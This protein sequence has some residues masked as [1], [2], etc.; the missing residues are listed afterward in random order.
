MS[1][2]EPS[3]AGGSRRRCTRA[4]YVDGQERERFF[5][6]ISASSFKDLDHC[7]YLVLGSAHAE[8]HYA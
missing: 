8:S 1:H 5:L 7:A 2:K 6:V 4:K 3:D